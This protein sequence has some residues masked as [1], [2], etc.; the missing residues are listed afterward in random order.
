MKYDLKRPSWLNIIFVKNTPKM[1]NCEII[2]IFRFQSY[3][4]WLT[5]KKI[6]NKKNLKLSSNLL[7]C[8][9]LACL[10]FFYPIQG[11]IGVRRACQSQKVEIV[12]KNGSK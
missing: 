9:I 12:G 1:G 7:F 3:F 10:N 8:P 2:D 4:S 6:S 11:K 5:V